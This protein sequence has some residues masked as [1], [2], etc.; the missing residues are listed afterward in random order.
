LEGKRGDVALLPLDGG[1]RR[2]G[3]QSRHSEHARVQIYAYHVPVF[4]HPASA[5]PT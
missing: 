1:P 4:A 2:L 5:A 3:K